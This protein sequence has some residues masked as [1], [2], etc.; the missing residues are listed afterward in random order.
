M[1]NV[2][3]LPGE[4]QLKDGRIQCTPLSLLM[5]R[6]RY[7]IDLVP[8][9]GSGAIAT[10]GQ[11]VFA[12]PQSDILESLV[13][14]IQLTIA[15][16]G[17]TYTTVTFNQWPNPVPWGIIKNVSLSGNGGAV[18]IFSLSGWGCQLYSRKRSDMDIFRTGTTDK[19][20]T[21]AQKLI[22]SAN[23]TSQTRAFNG[24]SVAASTTYSFNLTFELPISF[25]KQGEMALLKLQ[26][27][28]IFNLTFQWASLSAT[29]GND[30][31]TE[32]SASGTG[33]TVAG[34]VRVLAK[35]FKYLPEDQFEYSAQ[36]S[37]VKSVIEQ[38][39]PIQNGSNAI[40][41]VR[42]DTY[43][44]IAAE[45]YNNGA[46]VDWSNLSNIKLT[47]SNLE[48]L[49]AESAYTHVADR[50]LQHGDWPM[51]GL[52]EFDMRRRMGVKNH[53][54]V[55]DAINDR[56]IQNLTIGFDVASSLSLTGVQG[57]RVITEALVDAS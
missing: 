21:A 17:G 2:Q 46:P 33:Y 32:T 48:V 6:R 29:G 37:S 23:P 20:S 25:N 4:V 24:G 36:T 7:E 14:N 41:L 30:I 1:A 47:H 44:W 27:N 19:Y 5:R 56:N 15:T 22:G 8:T 28:A 9:G 35:F 51:D 49:A 11:T 31:V 39:Y 40:Q 42:N 55:L 10:N 16:N 12:L 18:N 13:V 53:M 26:N 52:M 38:I 3:L 54:D 57:T 45:A 50:F 43:T 34:T